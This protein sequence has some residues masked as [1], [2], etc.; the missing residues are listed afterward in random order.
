M[1]PN[2]KKGLL[3]L[4]PQ[5]STVTFP[6]DSASFAGSQRTYLNNDFTDAPQM[7]DWF[8]PTTQSV[9]ATRV[10]LDLDQTLAA[11]DVSTLSAQQI[12]YTDSLQGTAIRALGTST[13]QQLALTG[14]AMAESGRASS[15]DGQAIAT[16]LVAVR[17]A[18][19]GWADA[20]SPDGTLAGVNTLTTG[21]ALYALCRLGLRPRLNAAVGSALDWL[22]SQQRDD[23]SWLLPQHNSA[24]SSSWALL[25][26]ACVSNA[27][28]TAEF[29]PLTANGSPKAPVSESF[30]TTLNVT[31][32]AVDARPT[33]ISVTGGPPGAVVTVTPNALNLAGDASVAVAV[34]IAL[35]E[36][37]PADTSYPFL[38]TVSFA[39]GGSSVA[40]EVSAKFTTAIGSD[41]DAALTATT[42]TLAA[43][44]ALLNAG[45]S[46]PLSVRAD[47]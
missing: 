13:V 20:R 26:V 47:D 35:P 8:L 46:V 32:T 3:W 6:N 4:V 16:Q 30:T 29:D 33:T 39:A 25:A 41:P 7:F 34:T 24:V 38:A 27:G 15:I 12:S 2:I 18:D 40:S 10:L 28:G 22:I 44:P 1:L 31:N 19:A 14:I 42:T 36:G 37:L 5:A 23:G 11:S 45:S 43:L 17:T 21:Q 9:F